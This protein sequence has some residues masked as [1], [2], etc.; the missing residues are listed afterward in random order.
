MHHGSA[1]HSVV[2]IQPQKLIFTDRINDKQTTKVKLCTHYVV[3]R[4]K[5]PL[6]PASCSADVPK[7]HK[8]GNIHWL[9]L[10]L[11]LN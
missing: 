2:I 3:V 8:N 9:K 6:L 4:P 5:N 11:F 1:E 7:I 10:R